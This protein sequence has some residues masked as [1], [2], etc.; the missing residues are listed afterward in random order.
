MMLM[1]LAY[2][3][4]CGPAQYHQCTQNG[5]FSE[6]DYYAVNIFFASFF[7]LSQNFFRFALFFLLPFLHSHQLDIHL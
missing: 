5:D 7:M 1:R 2:L 3:S 6:G 4:L